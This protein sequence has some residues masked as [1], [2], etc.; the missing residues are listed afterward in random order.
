[1][2]HGEVDRDDRPEGRGIMLS[3]AGEFYEGYFKEGKKHG[4]GRQI[5]EDG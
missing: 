4:R 1:M 3:P 2:Y 5:T